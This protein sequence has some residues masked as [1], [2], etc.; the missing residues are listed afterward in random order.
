MGKA[1]Q[2]SIPILAQAQTLNEIAKV[3]P[4]GLFTATAPIQDLMKYADGTVGSIVMRNGKISTHSG[5]TEVA[6]VKSLNPAAIFGV[7]MQAMAFISGEYYMREIS[8][9][10]KSVDPK[11]D[12]LIGYHHDEKIGILK[13]VNRELSELTAKVNVD[14]AD[15]IACQE[16]KKRATDIYYEYETHIEGTT[17]GSKER[18]LNKTQE[19]RELGISLDESEMDFSIQMCYQAS[20]LRAKCKIA[21]IAIRLK[22]R[23]RQERFIT[24][25]LDELCK[26]SKA[27]FHHNIH[28]YIDERYA[29]IL[30]KAKK[31]A[32]TAKI[33]IIFGNVSEETNS[34]QF[35]KEI[36]L[37]KIAENPDDETFVDKVIQSF[38]KPKEM[39]ILF[40]ETQETQR[41]FVLDE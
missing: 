37:E 1:I 8:E 14:G 7:S 10:L 38:I 23:D 20:I 41:A 27:E 35:R 3:A 5:F 22:I 16:M 26:N 17:I 12:K 21:E 24:E 39:L 29:P 18:W 9:Q 40:D 34:I 33:P 2:G 15:I 4:N 30:E 36:I 6:T 11:L 28:L 25:Q 19:I 31:I 13:R 32:E